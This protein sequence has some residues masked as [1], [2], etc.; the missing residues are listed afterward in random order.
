MAK[1]VG[2]RIVPKH[3]GYWDKNQAYEMECIVYDQ[4]SGNSYISRKAVPAGTLL[5][6]T[7]Y[8]ALCSD[9][10][11]QMY[12]LNQHVTE[13]EAAILASNVATEA[14]VKA[15]NSATKQHVDSSL[16]ATQ[17]SLSSR[18]D[19]IEA[20]QDASSRASTDADADYA[21]EVVDARV[22]AKNTV[23]ANLG[24]NIRGIHK[25][26]ETTADYMSLFTYENALFIDGT[27]EILEGIVIGN[28]GVSTENENF[29]SVYVPCKKG[30][31]YCTTHDVAPSLFQGETFVEF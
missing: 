24:A 22:D 6:Q 12:M 31:R 20:R 1:Y 19:N 17:T 2:K 18:M 25:I 14:S 9:F 3:C 11:E 15:D 8:W 13:S 26:L 10:N 4:A 30:E 21:A 27:Q 29:N 28:G 23:H 5:T 16:A 7:D